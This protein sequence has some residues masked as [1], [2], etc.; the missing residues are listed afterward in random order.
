VSA[1]IWPGQPYPQGAWFD[2]VGTNF[3]VFAENAERVEL[4][5]FDENGF[6]TRLRLPEVTAFVHHGFVPD[7]TPGQRY[8]YRVHGP[9]EPANGMLYNP[10]KLLID[11]YAKA[12]EG[13]VDWED[14]S[15]F[16]YQAGHPERRDDR[17]SSASMP[18]SI[19]VDDRFD[20]TGDVL[21]KRPLHESVIYETHVKGISATHPGVPEELRG[22]YAGLASD[23]IVEHLVDLGITAVELLPVHHHVPEHGLVDLG[24]TNYWGYSTIGYF[25]PHAPYSASGDR[26]QQVREFKSMVKT[27]HRAGIEVILDVV[28]NH[29]GESGPLGPML[30]FRG[31]DNASYYRLDPADPRRYVDYTGTGNSL[32][33]RHPEVLK[34]IMDSLR[35]WITEMHVDGFR[36]D[37]ASALARDLHEV[38]KLAA[39]FDIIHQDP[40]VSAVKLI[41]E[42]WD[43]GDGGYQVGNFPVLWS[44]WNGKYRDGVRDYWRGSDWMLADFASR[45]TGSS[46]LYGF[47][48]RR[49]HASINFVTAHDGFTLRDLVSY[50]QKHNEANLEGNRD[51]ESHNR[52][53][54][55]GVEG[56]TSDPDIL[57]TRKRRARSILTT[58]LL[59]QGVPMLLGGDEIGRTQ[60]GNNNAYCQDNEISWYDWSNPDEDMLAY[61][62]AVI[63]L[64]EQHP[65]FRR[66]RWFEGRSVRASIHNDIAWYKPDGNAMTSDDWQRGYAKSLCVYLNGRGILTLD[67]RGRTMTD[68]SFLILFNAHHDLVHFTLPPEQ[69]DH[70]WEI[71]LYSAVG[72]VDDLPAHAPASGDVAGWSVAVLRCPRGSHNSTGIPT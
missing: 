64:R 53:W 54:N 36:F 69:S 49:P 72:L 5:L 48:G 45:F 25:A 17:D 29:T 44:E 22:T 39:F 15:V 43:V 27:L 50:N 13:S 56:P 2:G 47:A 23:A 4:C 3:A 60:G 46:D 51:G 30:S 21:L 32:N 6:E 18:R 71:V 62:R 19:V 7:V 57:T 58:L 26:G 70:E 67:E 61:T 65:V 37:L 10:D 31:I 63:R 33:V 41:A 1:P 9:W 14:G 20:W 24:L 42:P 40:V 38:D 55:S 16:A 34:L 35:Y 28:Y 59:S 8:G 52:S 12:I 66:R 68:D 11:P